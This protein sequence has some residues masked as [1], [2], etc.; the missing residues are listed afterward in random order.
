MMPEVWAFRRV[1]ARLVVPTWGNTAPDL[2]RVGFFWHS[3][4]VD[5]I[6]VFDL[7]VQNI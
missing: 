5:K 1:Q 2:A 4:G 6:C 7:V 3:E